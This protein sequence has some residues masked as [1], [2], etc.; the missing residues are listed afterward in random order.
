MVKAVVFDMDGVILD[1]EKVYRY[2]W[3]K[4]G[5]E[6]GLAQEELEALCNEIAGGTSAHTKKVFLKHYGEDFPYDAYRKRVYELMDI[7][8]KENGYELKPGVEELLKTLKEKK[9]KI[10]LATSTKEERACAYLKR[11]GL[12]EAF[13]K[14]IFGDMIVNGKPAPDIYLMACKA[15]QVLPEEAMGIEDSING[16][17]SSNSAGLYTIMVVDLIKPTKEIEA[18]A[19][20]IYDSLLQVIPLFERRG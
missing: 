5:Q 7:Y 2:H 9:I 20:G 13:D 1:S 4:V 10:G 11:A 6:Y 17:K 19:D 12:Y 15:L 18:I 16:V 8:I 3:M 14:L